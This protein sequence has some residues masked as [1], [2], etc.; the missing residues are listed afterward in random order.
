LAVKR[1]EGYLRA[2][3]T[4]AF[5]ATI[6]TARTALA[7]LR[8]ELATANTSKATKTTARQTETDTTKQGDLD[9]DLL[10]LASSIT[11][12]GTSITAAV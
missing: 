10:I 1:R 5:N 8:T 11:E 2:K 7:T 9:L 12:Y 3:E 4:E 6:A